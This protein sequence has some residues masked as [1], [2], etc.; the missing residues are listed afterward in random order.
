MIQQNGWLTCVFQQCLRS[1]SSVDYNDQMAQYQ[2]YI[3]LD[4]FS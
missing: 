1:I 3:R 2:W 4:V